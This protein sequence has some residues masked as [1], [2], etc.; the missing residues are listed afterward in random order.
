M[1]ELERY[2]HFCNLDAEQSV[3]GSILLEPKVLDDYKLKP[4]HFYDDK[5]VK[6]YK[7][8][9]FLKRKK[10]DISVI[11]ILETLQSKIEEIG[12]MG[13]LTDLSMSMHTSNAKYSEGIILE[14]YERRKQYEIAEK[15]MQLTLTKVPGDVRHKVIESLKNLEDDMKIDDEN[16]GHIRNVLTNIALWAEEDHG[17]ISGA[18][19]G[20]K[21]LDQY[22]G[23][24]QRKEVTIIGAR[25]SA[26]KTA[27]A[28]NLAQNYALNKKYGGPVC[29]LSIEMPDSGIAKR[30]I[31]S[32]THIDGH[33]MRN[34][35]KTF[36]DDDWMKMYTSIGRLSDSHFHIFDESIVTTEFIRNKCKLMKK[37]Y[38]NE[39]ILVIIDYLQLIKGDKAHRG[40]RNLEMGQVALELKQIA[41]DYD[42][43]I[44]V[45]SQLSR[46]VESREN[47]RPMLSDLKDSGDIEAMGDVIMLL[48]RDD[49]YNNES[50]EKGIIEIIIAKNRNGSIGTVKLLFKKEFSKFIDMAL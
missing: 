9:L 46:G 1:N 36:K 21:E 12:G 30:M 11:S 29:V 13:Y 20:F 16:D 8:L 24:L 47:K 3:L 14:H 7:T 44:V 49:Y 2:Q 42:L 22:L 10:I 35:S 25:P 39:H 4:E 18:R 43:S 48:Y 27:F 33:S 45:L 41:K 32:D 17:E 38:P 34:P 50:E 19:T 5:H 23:G 6:L 15:M 28:I 26:G 37:M 40:N 31:S